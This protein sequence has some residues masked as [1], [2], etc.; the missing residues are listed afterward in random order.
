[1]FHTRQPLQFKQ[2]TTRYAK[3][4]FKKQLHQ[5]LTKSVPF[6]FA[7]KRRCMPTC[8]HHAPVVEP[9]DAA[10]CTPRTLPSPRQATPSRH[11]QMGTAKVISKYT[12]QQNILF[13][14]LGPSTNT[15]TVGHA[16]ALLDT[17]AFRQPQTRQGI[18]NNNFNN[19]NANYNH[20]YEV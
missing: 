13:A 1:M 8:V 18:R 6:T 5:N 11:E 9:A 2:P 19:Y 4:T 16:E 7:V 10:P 17:E 15:R 3:P 14:C 20:W 12:I